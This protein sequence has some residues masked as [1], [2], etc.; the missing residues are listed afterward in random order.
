M[1]I[2]NRPVVVCRMVVGT[3]VAQLISG[4]FLTKGRIVKSH[5]NNGFLSYRFNTFFWNRL[6]RDNFL[7]SRFTTRMHNCS[8]L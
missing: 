3:P 6:L 2:T 4:P 8:S 7:K 1:V 5:L